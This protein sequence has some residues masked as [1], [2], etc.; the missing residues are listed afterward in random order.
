M[1]KS[2][3]EENESGLTVLTI[4]EALEEYKGKSLATQVILEANLNAACA[5]S[6]ATELGKLT[7][8][9]TENAGQ[10]DK[11]NKRIYYLNCVLTAA[12]VAIALAAFS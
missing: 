4:E 12:T 2:E 9:L 7:N 8:Q 3:T 1:L 5:K 10:S 11:L 6:V